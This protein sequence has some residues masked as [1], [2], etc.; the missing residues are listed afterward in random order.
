M[1]QIGYATFACGCKTAFEQTLQRCEFAKL[2]GPNTIFPDFQTQADEQTSQTFDLLMCL[3]CHG[4]SSHN[5]KEKKSSKC[6]N[7]KKWLR[8]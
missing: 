3:R 6:K 4:P 5:H 8:K 1:C 7:V 2:H